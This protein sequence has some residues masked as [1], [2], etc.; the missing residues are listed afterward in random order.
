MK[1]ARGNSRE[2]AGVTLAELLVSLIVITVV[3]YAIINFFSLNLF[4]NTKELKRSKLYYKAM[5]KIRALEKKLKNFDLNSGQTNYD[6]NLLN[7]LKRELG[8]PVE[9][10]DDRKS[11]QGEGNISTKTVV[12][13]N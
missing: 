4:Q 6:W 8:I 1:S 12:A 13:F 3:I 9:F 5:T 11:L 2:N 10:A 7:S